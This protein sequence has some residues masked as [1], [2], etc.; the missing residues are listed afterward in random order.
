MVASAPFFVP[1]AP[2]VQA[3]K[4]P[5][6]V[7]SSTYTWSGGLLQVYI[8]FNEPMVTDVNRLL[9][10]TL[11]TLGGVAI[12]VSFTTWVNSTQ[13]RL[14]AFGVADPVTSIKLYYTKPAIVANRCMAARGVL[15]DNFA[16]FI[17]TRE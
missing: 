15:L 8:N 3:S 10:F 6:A 5:V 12:G 14:S 11:K 7:T 2:L 16:D 9:G 13:G 17:V 1:K 4:P